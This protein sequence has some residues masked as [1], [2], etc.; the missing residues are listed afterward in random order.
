MVKKRCPPRARRAN[1]PPAH[2][3][4]IP[5]PIFTSRWNLLAISRVLPAPGS[6]NSRW[7]AV[8]SRFTLKVASGVQK[9]AVALRG[10]RVALGPD[11][12][13]SAFH[14]TSLDLEGEEVGRRV[15]IRSDV[16]PNGLAVCCEKKPTRWKE[17]QREGA[18]EGRKEGVGV[19]VG[20]GAERVTRCADRLPKG[21]FRDCCLDLI[22]YRPS[23]LPH[24]AA[25]VTE[26]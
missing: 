15:C 22:P 21:H 26:G 5:E 20:S 19:G 17:R 12:A 10:P 1:T 25:S 8:K 3:V 11:R 4:P 7:V 24:L 18:S 23:T 2:L 13:T 16:A 14:D 9:V 6:A